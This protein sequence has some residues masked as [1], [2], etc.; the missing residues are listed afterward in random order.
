LIKRGRGEEANDQEGERLSEAKGD[1]AN[2]DSRGRSDGCWGLE[3]WGCSADGGEARAYT[4]SSEIARRLT[5]GCSEIARRSE[6]SP[7]LCSPPPSAAA[8]PSV[9][10][11]PAAPATT[12]AVAAA[13]S[14][15]GCAA[16]SP[17]GV[18]GR[19]MLDTVV[20]DG[21]ALSCASTG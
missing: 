13:A 8:A 2:A 3:A 4:L 20:D 11:I 19:Y 6:S 7:A 17:G 14:G 9:G 21:S 5:G 15:I 12:A 10:V 1:E 16:G 18:T